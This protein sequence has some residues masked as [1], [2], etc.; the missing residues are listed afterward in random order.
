MS[1]PYGDVR[2]RTFH[3]AR[4]LAMPPQAHVVARV[5][6][7]VP[8]GARSRTPVQ[9]H[10]GTRAVGGPRNRLGTLARGCGRATFAA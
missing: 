2:L 8:V 7:L 3:T 4:R 1:Q 10:T 6:G 5:S 9:V